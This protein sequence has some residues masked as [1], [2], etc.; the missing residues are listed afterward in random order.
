MNNKCNQCD[1]EWKG[2]KEARACP[3]CKRYDW[4]QNKKEGDK[5]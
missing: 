1:Y 5:K 2:K 4:K 3:R